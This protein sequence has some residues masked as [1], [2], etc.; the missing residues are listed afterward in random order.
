MYQEAPICDKVE[1]IYSALIIFCLRSLGKCYSVL[2]FYLLGVSQLQHP[3]SAR[4]CLLHVPHP[5]SVAER[6]HR[7][8]PSRKPW[9]QNFSVVFL[10]DAHRLVYPHG[11]EY[12]GR[13]RGHY[14]QGERCWIFLKRVFSHTFSAFMGYKS[15]WADFLTLLITSLDW[16]CDPLP[17][18]EGSFPVLVLSLVSGVKLLAGNNCTPEISAMR[19]VNLEHLGTQSALPPTSWSPNLLGEVGSTPIFCSGFRWMLWGLDEGAWL[20]TNDFSIAD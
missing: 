7:E 11:G 10:W 4:C 3:I 16:A 19:A 13:V 20:F 15:G 14:M 2:L 9:A 6:D 18:W 5:L 12:K 1:I 17:G 8:V